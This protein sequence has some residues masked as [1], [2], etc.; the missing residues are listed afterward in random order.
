[1]ARSVFVSFLLAKLLV[2]IRGDDGAWAVTDAADGGIAYRVIDFNAGKFCSGHIRTRPPRRRAQLFCQSYFTGTRNSASGF[3]TT[4][5]VPFLPSRVR[6]YFPA[7]DGPVPPKPF[8]CCKKRCNVSMGARMKLSRSS[9]RGM[10]SGSLAAQ[11]RS[12]THA[13]IGIK[14]ARQV[15]HRLLH[16]CALH[17]IIGS[18]HRIQTTQ[19]KQD[20]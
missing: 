18:C 16:R 6:R 11:V 5:A 2:A 13:R 7:E 1:V 4:G 19:A 10:P 20:R 8:T 12:G 14:P 17:I 3:F 9:S 15:L